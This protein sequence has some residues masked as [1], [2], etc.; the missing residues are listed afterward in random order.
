M[1]L[2]GRI[3]VVRCLACERRLARADFQ[4]QLARR[5]PQ[6]VDLRAASAPDGDAELQGLDFSTFDVPACEHCGGML[7]PDVVFFGETFAR[8]RRHGDAGAGAR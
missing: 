6:W 1:E 5:N 2:H 8:A 4:Q 7:K 3:D